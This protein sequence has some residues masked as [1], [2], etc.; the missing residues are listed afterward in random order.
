MSVRGYTRL[1]SEIL[2]QHSHRENKINT[3]KEKVIFGLLQ[4]EQE[5][6]QQWPCIYHTGCR[7]RSD[8]ALD[9]STWS[10][11]TIPNHSGQRDSVL[12]LGWLPLLLKHL[13]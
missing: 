6:V 13:N 12:A 7:K 3:N 11:K 10:K 8:Y 1:Q 4:S 2:S 9:H 5:T